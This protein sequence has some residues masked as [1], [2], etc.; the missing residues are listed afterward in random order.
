VYL[1][2]GSPGWVTD[3]NPTNP[4]TTDCFNHGTSTAAIITGSSALSSAA[5]GAFDAGAV[6]VAAAGNTGPNPARWCPQRSRRRS[7][8]SARST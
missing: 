2:A 8:A 7:S 6:V 3:L 1:D 5:D 4:D